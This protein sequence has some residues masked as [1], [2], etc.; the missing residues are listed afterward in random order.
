MLYS[1][2]SVTGSQTHTHTHQHCLASSLIATT[3]SGYASNNQFAGLTANNEAS[4]DGTAETIVESINSHMANLT[5]SV[6]TQSNAANNANTTMFNMSMQQ[7]AANKAQRNNEHARM[8]QQFAMMTTNQPGQQQ[9]ATQNRLRVTAGSGALSIPVLVPTQQWSP[10]Q[11][12]VP[13]EGRGRGGRSSTRCGR[14]NQRGPVQGAPLL[15]VGG[16]Q[17]I[18]YIPAG[19]QPQPPPQ[20][21]QTWLNS[22]PTKT[23][24]SAAVSTWMMGILA[25]PAPIKKLDI[26]TD[27]LAPTT[28]K[29]N[30]P[31]I[32][33]AARLCT[34]RCTQK[35]VMV[36][37]GD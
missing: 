25:P 17:I 11:Q 26:K 24:V 12:W 8:I 2:S 36:R 10:A 3:G 16:N 4:D 20:G 32:S 14:C 5:A 27:S 31:T 29:T 21:T 33:S 30:A 22:G 9:F 35:S 7:M 15:F 1:N 37:G 34:R 6:I 23:C 13:P 19:V 28:W 18:P